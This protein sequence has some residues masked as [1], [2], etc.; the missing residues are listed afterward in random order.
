MRGCVLSHI[1]CRVTFLSPHI[2]RMEYWETN[3]YFYPLGNGLCSR[4]KI[5]EMQMPRQVHAK[6]RHQQ[7]KTAWT[8]SG[9][10]HEGGPLAHR[11]E[12]VDLGWSRY[13]AHRYPARWNMMVSLVLGRL[14]EAE[15]GAGCTMRLCPSGPLRSLCRN[16]SAAWHR[17]LRGRYPP[18]LDSKPL[19]PVSR[20]WRCR[21]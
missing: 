3:I 13:C 21:T 15:R 5:W 8:L 14:I 2:S 9:T 6:A 19:P 7:G 10:L 12:N 20:P 4:A 16:H 11:C 18:P 1:A 17:R